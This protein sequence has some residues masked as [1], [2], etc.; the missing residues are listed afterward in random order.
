MVMF[1][2]VPRPDEAGSAAI[3]SLQ[4]ARILS[5]SV[6]ATCGRVWAST[7]ATSERVSPDIIPLAPPSAVLA[8][9]GM[10]ALGILKEARELGLD[11]P[12]SLA[13]VGFA[14]TQVTQYTQPALTMVSLPLYDMGAAAMDVLRVVVADPAASP[15][16]MMFDG[17]LVVRESC[18]EHPVG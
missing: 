5:A 9:G 18:G 7:G 6:C 2:S 10:L 4:R 12:A 14:D 16:R 15:A 1:P 8:S 3:S 17:V 13:V 11:V